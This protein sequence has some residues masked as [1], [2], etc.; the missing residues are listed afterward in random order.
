MLRRK[1]SK[2]PAGSYAFEMKRSLQDWLQHRVRA[3]DVGQATKHNPKKLTRIMQHG[4]QRIA[5]L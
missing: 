5:K 3:E 1:R 4:M 2:G